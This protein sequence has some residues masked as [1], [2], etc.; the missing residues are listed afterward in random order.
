MKKK[1]K[2]YVDTIKILCDIAVCADSLSRKLGTRLDPVPKRYLKEFE[3]LEIA[4]YQ[5]HEIVETK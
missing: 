5:L 3:E 1:D 4:L 2:E